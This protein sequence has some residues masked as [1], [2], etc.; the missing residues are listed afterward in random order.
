M[1][2]YLDF[3]STKRF[4][5]FIIGKTLNKPNGPQ[6]FTQSSYTVQTLSELSNADLPDVD[7][8]RGT[9]LLQPQNSNIF[10][11]FEYFVTENINTLPR[12][13]NLQLYPYFNSSNHN[14]ISVMSNDNYD[15]ESELMKFAAL[16]IRQNPNGPVLARITRN[17]EVATNGRLR[18]LDALNGN[19]A[20]AINI[21]T[22]REPL[23]EPNN[24]ITVAKTLPGK[25]IDFLQTVAGVEF[26]W[27]EIP[28]DYLSDPRNPINNRPEA[29][30]ELGRVFQDVTGALGSL[31][32]IQRRPKLGRKP[33]DLMIE[34]LGEGQKN[35][36]YDNLSFSKYAP[37]YTTTARSQNTSKI[38]N[39]VD[40]LAQGVKNI[41]GAEAP[42]G[43]A[44][45]GDD[46]G[47]DVKYAMGDFND[48]QIRSSYYL[49]F[50]FDP[51]QAELFQR[52][53]NL[54]QGGGISG[55]LTW[56]SKNSKNKYGTHN[57]EWDSEQ[58]TWVDTLST[59]FGFREDSIL[60]YT[61]EL[62]DTLPLD[63]ATSRTHVANVIDQTSRF[64]KD[65]DIMMSRGSAVKYVKN[66][67]GQ[68]AGVEFCRVWTK[69]RSYMNY[70]D[71]MKR[72]SN[73]RKYNGS[74]ISH[75]WNLNIGPMSNG[76]KSFNDST[77]I[78][79]SK[80]GG[81]L[82]WGE[83]F[84][85]KKYMFS[86]ENLAWK[87][88]ELP[89]FTVQELPYCE[90]GPNGGRVMWFPPYDLKIS[91][92]N[93]AKWEENSFLGRPEPIYT[94]QNTTRS[95]QVSFKVIV[96]HP[97]ILNLLVREHFEG[98]SD[99]ESDNYIN[100]FFS[101]CEDIDFYDLIRR[102][103]TITPDESKKIKEYLEGGT[104]PEVI[105]KYRVETEPIVPVVPDN[106]PEKI[107]GVKLDT[108]LLFAN[109]RPS[110]GKNN[111]EYES[112]VDYTTLYK[113]SLGKDTQSYINDSKT[114][115]TNTLTE[116][117]T[118]ANTTGNTKQ[119]VNARK[120]IT[121]LFKQPDG[122]I[123]P[124]LHTEKIEKQ[125]ELLQT[126][127]DKGVKNFNE[128]EKQ[129]NTLKDDIT[130]GDV[131]EITISTL[132]SCSAVADDTYN[133]KL[134]IRR[135]HSILKDIVKRLGGAE[136]VV[137]KIAKPSSSGEL[138]STS[139]EQVIS[140]KELG[141]ADREG[142]LVFKATNKGEKVVNEVNGDC[143]KTEF[144]TK[145]LKINTAI[146]FGC[147]QSSVKFNYT[148]AV[149]KQD[150][151]KPTNDDVPPRTR[152]I[153]E[154]GTPPSGNRKPPIDVMKRIIMKT[155]SECYYFK[156]LEEKDP[157]VFGSLKEK[158]KYFHP[159]FHS[160][161]PEGLNARLTF[162]NQ[163]L[164]PGD[165]IPIKG[166]SDDLDTFARNTTFGPPP[167]CVLRIGDFYHSKIVIRDINITFDDSTWD[168]NPEGIG[169]Q[170]MLANV[171]LQVAFIGGQG[172][173]KPVERLQN[174]LSSNFYANTEMYDERA[175]ATVD[176]PYGKDKKESDLFTKSFLEGLQV[177]TPPAV[178]SSNKSDG[179]KLDTDKFIGAPSTDGKSLEYRGI[180][181]DVFEKTEG[182]FSSYGDAYNNVNKEFGPLIMKML[183][184]PQYREINKYDIF[185][186][187]STTPGSTIELF[188]IPK[189]GTP[190]S[191]LISNLKLKLKE[192]TENQDVSSI[193]GFE[194]VLTQPQLIKSN[195]LLR[196]HLIKYIGDK[197]DKLS[198]NEKVIGVENS[199]DELIKSLDKVN[200][201]VKYGYDGKVEKGGVASK[202]VLSGYTYNLIYDEYESCIEYITENNDK[203][204]EKI[205]NT[206]DFKSITLTPE[207][208]G[209][210]LS[211][212]LSFEDGKSK[213]MN[214][215][216]VDTTIFKT[217]TVEKLTKRLDKFVEAP[218]DVKFK[219][220]KFKNQKTENP[221]TF[222]ITPPTTPGDE[223]ITDDTIKT[224]LNSLNSSDSPIKNLKLNYF[225]KTKKTT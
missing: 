116:L 135:S 66:D 181:K 106:T 136:S 213:L 108:Y 101:G 45:I 122:K 65:G 132:S 88:S 59:K 224:E 82:F 216:A 150:D 76:K 63:G 131:Q 200:F 22:G 33:S 104:N 77:N 153:L 148:K 205:N 58:S 32:G 218:D 191:K 80:D 130:K 94:Y 157:V 70:S 115:L 31:F 143:S 182:F 199:R 67:T 85:A 210:I 184:S 161:T 114:A 170:P 105:Q 179:N 198:S 28:G 129:L 225:R 121:T 201:L 78:V 37:N 26:P 83:G 3:D 14:L 162:L 134:S 21:V 149:K 178:D 165:T 54:S 86:I 139:F 46:R 124:T 41:L 113:Q 168:M 151:Q 126:E 196:P 49:S 71:T 120:D 189:D 8:N 164:R 171:S 9:D 40:N 142:N 187:T 127:I 48:R 206:I 186:T 169:M 15:T 68:E 53:K 75:P 167:I 204:Y 97:S 12:R 35:S 166:I 183:F 27:S 128:Y 13:A 192:Y 110:G 175:I 119:V 51:V 39:F 50:M 7:F 222:Q 43:V 109:D 118:L 217:E 55:N 42:A 19:T 96:D 212:L 10:K 219:F 34:Y 25:A 138:S 145:S 5:D 18:F 6:T 4:R 17:L 93:S 20:T 172:L 2:S 117:L 52:D 73:I 69:D 30:T 56:I 155:L 223:V 99:E 29:R 220:K 208:Y 79:P 112:D 72:T 92:Q 174:A 194:K 141:F 163:C 98:M 215:F 214:V 176:N 202:A 203:L 102:Y 154:D 173:D 62:L 107:E 144:I 221:I 146:A 147:R 60:G 36:L 89:G 188:G 11:P 103:T 125:K 207:I 61:Q 197:I 91:E 190:H 185:N 159:A 133:Y 24:K 195:E 38:F 193:I 1:P 84:Y 23:I 81:G 137:K 90:R 95:G 180:V 177:A 140:F 211:S 152:L 111:T 209:S 100:A 47:N 158:L 87:T 74:V 64:F 156:T 160:M 57:K 44:Y 123:D 16:N